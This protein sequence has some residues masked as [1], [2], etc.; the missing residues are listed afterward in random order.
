MGLR[1]EWDDNK[2]SA[3]LKNH[4]VSFDEAKT[5]F[6]SRLARVFADEA[7]SM[8]EEREIIIGYS[9]SNRLLIVCF[10]ERGESIRIISA[11]KATKK[12]RQDYEENV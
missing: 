6:I 10:T 2:A 5:V 12:E 11:R 9:L 7:R 4:R 3:N 1:F 8:E